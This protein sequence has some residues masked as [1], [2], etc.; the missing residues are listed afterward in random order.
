MFTCTKLY[1]DISFAHRQHRHEG[2]CALIHGHNWSLEVQ[3][4]CER[5]DENGFVID[6]GRLTFLEEWIERHLDHACVFNQD[7]PLRER[8]VQAAPGCWKPYVIPN[9]SSE[10]IA[11]HLF[12]IFDE[13]VRRNSGGRAFIVS[14][15]VFED[16]RNRACFRNRDGGD[17]EATDHRCPD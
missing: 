17:H 16:S 8:L 3:F 15:A 10:G 7:D 2:P 11:R 13:L 9:C 5:L 4:G 1:T 12:G 14:V 6:F